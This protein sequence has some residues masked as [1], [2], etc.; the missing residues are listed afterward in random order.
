VPDSANAAARVSVVRPF[1]IH[2]TFS[3]PFVTFTLQ[4]S[5]PF[6]HGGD[7][8][9]GEARPGGP[10]QPEAG[11]KGAGGEARRHRVGQQ[12]FTRAC[13]PHSNLANNRFAAR[14]FFRPKCDGGHRLLF[15]SRLTLS[16]LVMSGRV[17]P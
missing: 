15:Q 8:D 10:F 6:D 3:R 12:F 5:L 7:G 9:E 16:N 1:I 13:Q 2:L 4:N 17:N 11:N 14:P